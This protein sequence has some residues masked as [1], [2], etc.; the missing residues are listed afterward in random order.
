VDT[1]HGAILLSYFQRSIIVNP[2]SFSEYKIPDCREAKI[3]K[4]NIYPFFSNP[5]NP[6]G[7]SIRF[8]QNNAVR[9]L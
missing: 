1:L 5:L 7:K 9:Y 3:K 8:F 4:N 2:L 6:D